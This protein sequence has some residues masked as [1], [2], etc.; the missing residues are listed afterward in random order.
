MSID[1]IR[2]FR[3]KV[4]GA[5]KAEQML[6]NPISPDQQAR[7]DQSPYRRDLNQVMPE[8]GGAKLSSAD[9]APVEPLEADVAFSYGSEMV[10]R[11]ATGYMPRWSPVRPAMRWLMPSAHGWLT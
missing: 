10:E 5:T 8:E 2:E 11:Q 9:P 7:Q 1:E 6:G 4:G 3:T